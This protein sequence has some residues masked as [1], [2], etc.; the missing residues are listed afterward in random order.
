MTDLSLPNFRPFL[1]AIEPRHRRLF[2]TISGAH[3]YGF[4]SEDSDYDLRGCF[5]IP[6]RRMFGMERYRETIEHMDDGPNPNDVV[7][8]EARKYAGL[9]LKNNGYVLEQIMSR[10]V[11][12]TSPWHEELKSIA[13][14]CVN[15]LSLNHYIG[16]S[17]QQMALMR[18]RPDKQV[19]ILLYIFRVLM[20]GIH[21]ARTGEVEPNIVILNET[22]RLP[23]I[24]ELV[25]QKIGREHGALAG[26][27]PLKYFQ[28]QYEAM[29]GQLEDARGLSKLPIA[30]PEAIVGEL[31]DW[32]VRLRLDE[33][34][35]HGSPIELGV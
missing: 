20:T 33:L 19:K 32:L 16:F 30:P 17:N 4:P 13:P 23:F 11:V 31:D 10:L 3:L 15:V 29:L 25:A 5:V 7:L 35:R 22:F 24:D 12:E 27:R 8:H 6:T 34:E 2:V 14:R 1:D 28:R 9:L 26:E 21:L 18:R